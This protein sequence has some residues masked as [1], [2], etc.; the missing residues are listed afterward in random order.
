MAFPLTQHFSLLVK[1]NIPYVEAFQRL[2]FTRQFKAIIQITLQLDLFSIW[3]SLTTDASYNYR[4]T[5]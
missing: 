3:C 4:L 2:N 5:V 1:S